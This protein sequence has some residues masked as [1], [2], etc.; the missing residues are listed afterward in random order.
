MNSRQF[1]RL[2]F[3]FFLCKF[4]VSIKRTLIEFIVYFD[5]SLGCL[6]RLETLISFS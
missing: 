5:K 3:I 4:H 1:N 6:N 2:E